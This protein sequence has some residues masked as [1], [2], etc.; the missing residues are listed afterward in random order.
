[1]R[2]HGEWLRWKYRKRAERKPPVVLLLDISGSMSQYSRAVLYFCH[3]L[4]QSASDCTSSCSAR[5]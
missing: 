3:A 2:Q 5:G 1:V 4:T